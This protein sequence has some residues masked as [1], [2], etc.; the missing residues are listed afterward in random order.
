M[1]PLSFRAG[2]DENAVQKGTRVKFIVLQRRASPKLDVES[3]RTS[4]THHLRLVLSE[5]L[6]PSR[7]NGLPLWW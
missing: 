3:I 2:G 1:I 6:A 4:D 5:I 7:R